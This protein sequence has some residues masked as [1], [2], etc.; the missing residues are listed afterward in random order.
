MKADGIQVVK[1]ERPEEWQ[2][3]LRQIGAYDFYHTSDYHAL[4]AER[5]EAQGELFFQKDG[6]EVV[7][8]PLLVKPIR[9]CSG[10]RQLFE[11]KSVY[12]Y[13]GWLTSERATMAMRARFGREL[14]S[15]FRSQGVVSV[16]SRMHPL[17]PGQFCE[18]QVGRIE[19][20]GYTLA[21]DLRQGLDSYEQSL[22]K[23][24]RYEIRKLRESGCTVEF[25]KEAGSLDEFLALYTETMLRVHANEQY[26]FDRSYFERLMNSRQFDLDVAVARLD[27]VMCA[28]A[29]FTCCNGLVQYHLSCSRAG[30]TRFPATKLIIDEAFR[31]FAAAGCRW[32]HLGG[33]LAAQKDSLYAFKLGFG[34]EPMP[35]SV[36]KWIVCE[37]EYNDL[38]N[39]AENTVE[40]GKDFFPAFK[41]ANR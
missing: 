11:A 21:L 5:E 27:G 31:R 35:F 29:L 41:I 4:E 2:A 15:Y 18:L 33:G 34:G 20:L 24:H 3:V 36:L 38:C 26:F 14:E 9:R 8:V 19:Q 17:L 23:G 39:D 22:A 25:E 28:M 16:F 30:V 1:S 7:A 10:S 32:L 40:E 13:G 6:E 12:G 37:D